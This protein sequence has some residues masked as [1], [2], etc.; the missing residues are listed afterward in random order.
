V[1]AA[2]I[3]L[4]LP[5]ARADAPDLPALDGWTL[6]GQVRSYTPSDL[7][8]FIDGA[9]ETYL[10]YAFVDLTVGEYRES[11][12]TIVRAEI[13]TH[14]DANNA[15]G[16]YALERASDYS[17]LEI[18]VEGYEGAGILNFLRGERYV[19]LSTGRHGV[20]GAEALRSVARRMDAALGGSKELPAGLKRLPVEGRLPR[21][22]GYV[23]GDFLGYGFLRGAFTAR[24]DGGAMLFVMDFP[25]QGKA[26]AALRSLLA[27]APGT[28]AGPGRYSI[29]DPHNGRI[30]LANS[31]SILYGSVNAADAAAERGWLDLLDSRIGGR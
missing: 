18:G 21:T 1:F 3:A 23:P 8:D 10:A 12:G 28:P 30:C 24:Y 16:I 31:D 11:G 22:E 29:A 13:Y 15:F 7:W 5:S 9:A 14:A 25:T 6:T 26:A 20:T 17:F 27:T 2:T 4:A 19:K